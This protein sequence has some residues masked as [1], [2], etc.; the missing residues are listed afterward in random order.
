[1][2]GNNRPY[3]QSN[4]LSP[5]HSL[6][7]FRPKHTFDLALKNNEIF[8]IL[9]SIAIPLA[10]TDLCLKLLKLPKSSDRIMLLS[11]GPLHTS[12][13]G[14]R[15]YESH[16]NLEQSAIYGASIAYRSK[17]SSNNIGLVSSPDVVAGQTI[18]LAI[19]GDSYTEGQ[20]GYAWMKK[21]QATWSKL[22]GSK[23]INY[24]IAGSGFEDFMVAGRAA[25]FEYKAK[26]ILILFIEHDAYRPY[27]KMAHNRW[28]SFYSNGKLDDILGPLTCHLYGV[29]WHHVPLGLSDQRLIQEG[30][31]RQKHGLL[32]A[33][34]QLVQR[35]ARP[36][37]DVA[38]E[39]T[40]K[41]S[42]TLRFGPIPQV[43]SEAISSIR[44]LYGKDNVLMVQLPDRAN[45]NRTISQ[46]SANTNNFIEQ[47]RTA[48]DVSIADLS[49]TCRLS[50]AD[51][52]ALDNHPNI[53]G[54][55]KLSLCVENN[56]VIQSFVRN[57]P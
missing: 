1:V 40:R 3:S 55:K 11:G 36:R 23:S 30:R 5:R 8:L 6:V 37:T 53:Y 2:P 29:V 50:K 19:A 18:D 4:P 14:Y 45:E 34:N 32:P 38:R 48:T 46:L 21:T 16:Q 15:R 56:T 42:H 35:F 9:A 24:A 17:Y 51:F 7:Q 10:L 41:P 33:L 43:S 57:P 13:Q 27:Q 26:K 47:L 22:W 39:Q 28:C 31:A 12:T 52:H 25:K 54:Y 20:G 49:H 44:K